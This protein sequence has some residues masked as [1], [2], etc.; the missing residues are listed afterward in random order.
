MAGLCPYSDFQQTLEQ[1]VP[2]E[3][4][5]VRLDDHDRSP[6]W[7]DLLGWL[8]IDQRCRYTHHNAWRLQDAESGPG[9]LS[10]GEANLVTRLTMGLFDVEEHRQT[11]RLADLRAESPR[12]QAERDRLRAT[13]EQLRT[14]L[15]A[16]ATLDGDRPEVPLFPGLRTRIEEQRA[17]Q[18]RLLQDPETRWEF[19]QADQDLRQCRSLMDRTTGRLEE[20]TRQRELAA[21]QLEAVSRPAEGEA[22]AV[23]VR[24]RS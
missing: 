8:I 23:L 16:V 13:A 24:W 9:V 20:L 12:L 6:G 17:S 19:G 1:F 11:V 7:T 22:L 4:G 5:T 18:E 2:P 21:R 10:L 3:F 15:L 14:R